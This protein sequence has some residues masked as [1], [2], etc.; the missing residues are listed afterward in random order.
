MASH[1]KPGDATARPA[2]LLGFAGILAGL[3]LPFCPVRAQTTTVTWPVPGQPVVSS[4]VIVVPYRPLHLQASIPCPALRTAATHAGPVIVLTTGTDPASLTVRGDHAEISVAAGGRSVRLPVPPDSDTC[5]MQIEA[6]PNGIRVGDVASN[7]ATALPAQPVPKVFGFRTGLTAADAAGMQVRAEIGEPFLTRPGPLKIALTLVQLIAAAVAMWLLPRPAPPPRPRRARPQLWWIDA[8]VVAAL[9]GWAVIGP[10]A[11]DDGWATMIA[12][13]EAATGNPG[14]YYRWWNAA[15]A[16]FALGQQLLAPLTDVSLAPLWLRMPST[17]L[18]VATWLVLTRGLLP[19]ALPKIAATARIRGLAAIC[20]LA[21]WLP[22]NLGTRPESYV[23]LGVTATLALAM[24]ARS[25]AGVGWL[26]LIVALTVPISPNS[27]IVA[28]PIV[29]FAPRLIAVLR[30]VA[31]SRMQL[32]SWVVLLCCIATVALTT[33]FADQTW[34]GAVIAT[35]WHSFFGPSL[36]WYEEPLRYHYLLQLDQ[37]GTFAK[38]LPVLLS[39][40]MLPIVVLLAR[41]RGDWAGRV[42]V[43]LAATV[44]LAL[45]LFAL[46]PSK[47]SY[48][49]GAAAGLFAALLTV[50]I[51]MLCR[52]TPRARWYAAHVGALGLVLTAGAAALVFA[53]PNAWWLPAV[54]DV[55]WADMAP[56]PLGLPLAHPML[57][58]GL[59][60]ALSLVAIAARQR[61]AHRVLSVGPAVVTIAAIGTGLALLVGSF[62]AAPIRRPSGSL[63]LMNIRQI[64]GSR[65]CGLADDIDVLPDG[66]VLDVSNSPG[67]ANM[68]F[69]AQGGFLPSA[70]PPDPPGQATSTFLWGSRG[71]GVAA[72]ATMTSPWFLL[73]VLPRDSGIAVSVSG[74]TD[75]GNT[76]A[77]EFGR[78]GGPEVATLGDRTPPD[79]PPA[80]EDPDHPLWRT[81]GV[82]ATDVPPGADRVRIRA[83]DSRTDSFGWLAFTGP[84]LRSIVPLNR[85]LAAHG[86]VLIS[87]PESFLFPCVRNIAT[88]RGAVAQTPV[89]I[90]ESPRPWLTDDRNPDIGGTFAEL[91]ESGELHEIPSRL[92]GHPEVDWGAVKVSGDT[93]ARD[94]Y[95][96]TVTEVTVPGIGGVAH[97]RAER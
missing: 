75:D 55:P 96:R 54:Y 32:A 70:P 68:G 86:P 81:I 40:A 10:L 22:F 43:R 14:N 67:A 51:V 47:W 42:A 53:G 27:V 69:T 59:L 79:H 71:T 12:R 1:P 16:P 15:E 57:W 33:I 83:I 45:A 72:T 60:A 48:H 49:F 82:D 8:A 90:I 29:V 46:S 26:L 44:T 73:P 13:N 3:A 18:A 5:F 28:A 35:D 41:R 21:A 36:P 2:L 24:S 97:Q 25:P 95:Q 63:A 38:R 61:G 37:Q 6:G 87:W 4:S 52:Q 94:A 23:A 11:V 65:S 93:A 89:T 84:R 88:V 34:D 20:L 76:L 56:R 66:A 64:S 78:Y 85:F 92:I 39:T 19:T 7:H 74:R 31:V 77:L 80:G 17:A 9:A 30:A 62:I 58:I 91:A 50:G